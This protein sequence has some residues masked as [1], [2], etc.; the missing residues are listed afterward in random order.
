MSL[1]DTLTEL[2]RAIRNSKARLTCVTAASAS[3]ITTYR[4]TY[5]YSLLEALERRY[6][7]SKIFT[8]EDNFRYLGKQYIAEHPSKNSNIDLYGGDFSVFLRTR[9]E[10][11]DYPYVSDLAAI[12]D[13]LYRQDPAFQVLIA[14]GTMA[15]WEALQTDI[16]PE[17]IVIDPDNYDRINYVID[18]DGD[19]AVQVTPWSG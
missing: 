4:T 19:D 15:I 8:G 17:R 14:Q 1:K 13:V 10:L 18:S 7:A 11:R 9:K 5:L 2:S 16:P 6:P 12:D 3:N